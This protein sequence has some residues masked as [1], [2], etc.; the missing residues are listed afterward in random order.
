MIRSPL[1]GPYIRGKLIQYGA[2]LRTPL[3]DA[4]D[5]IYVILTEIPHEVLTCLRDGLTT[6]EAMID[7]EGARATW[8]LLPDHQDM[9]RGLVGG[10]VPAQGAAVP[11]GAVTR[12]PSLH[13]AP[14]TGR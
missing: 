9:S 14:N 4:L 13:R 3:A 12:N 1:Y 5:L 2:D 6:A 10:E 11:E 7:P 8:G